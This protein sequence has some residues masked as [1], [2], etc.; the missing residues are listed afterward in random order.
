MVIEQIKKFLGVSAKKTEEVSA[1]E[2]VSD[3]EMLKLIRTAL[4]NIYKNQVT[5]L[6][7]D[8]GNL[9]QINNAILNI[10]QII[11]FLKPVVS[12]EPK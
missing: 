12:E 4:A 2:I 7:P 10:N 9:T 8:N 1:D 11:A 3:Y 5:D 6:K